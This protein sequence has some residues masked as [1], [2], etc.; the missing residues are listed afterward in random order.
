MTTHMRCEKCSGLVIN[1]R[2]I[3]IMTDRCTPCERGYAEMVE[4]A[5]GN[6]YGKYEK[7]E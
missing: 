5:I 4:L 7:E 3:N 1:P 2:L 6:Y